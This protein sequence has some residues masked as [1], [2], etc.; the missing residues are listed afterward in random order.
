MG[1]NAVQTR[2]TNLKHKPALFLG[3]RGGLQTE[4]YPFILCHAGRFFLV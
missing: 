1:M 4:S 2:A 3:G